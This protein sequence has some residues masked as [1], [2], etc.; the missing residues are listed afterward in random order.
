M[1]ADE[2]IAELESLN[3]EIEALESRYSEAVAAL[4]IAENNLKGVTPSEAAALAMS[5]RVSATLACNRALEDHVSCL[6]QQNLLN[7]AIARFREDHQSPLVSAADRYLQILTCGAHSRLMIDD[8]NA[9]S[10]QLLVQGNDSPKPRTVD[11]LS[12]GTRD[13]LYLALRLAGLEL[14]L[15]EGRTSLPFVADD[16]F[17]NFDD[18]RAAAGFTALAQLAQRTQVIYYTHH[19]HLTDVAQSTLGEAV[20]VARLS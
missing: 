18:A 12:E 3:Q 16:L 13:Q 11:T 8:S 10:P 2:L 19:E 9:R 7:W 17:V 14:H 5:E 6:I 1:D 15:D 4:R 20:T